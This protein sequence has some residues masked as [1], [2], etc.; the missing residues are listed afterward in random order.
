MPNETIQLIKNIW[1]SSKF[2]L[3]RSR[4]SK[5]G[6]KLI[7]QCMLALQNNT[8]D[9]E[10][11]DKLKILT[12]MSKNFPLKKKTD[13]ANPA[14]LTKKFKT[15]QEYLVKLKISTA[16]RRKRPSW[17]KTDSV[18]HVCLTKQSNW[19]KIFAQARNSNCLEQ[20]IL[21]LNKTDSTNHAFLTQNNPIDLKYLH[22]LKI[23]TALTKTVPTQKKTEST[24]HA[25]LTK[26]SN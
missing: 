14:Y 20:K 18:T 12:V 4:I 6:Q 23:A 24:N 17:K 13:S 8:I 15:D 22:K 7:V 2:Q 3:P 26:Q 11:L 19:L 10:D 9:Q 25:G 21:S 1:T 5:H 16:S